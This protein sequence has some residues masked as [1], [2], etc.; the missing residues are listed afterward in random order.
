VK[1]PEEGEYVISFKG[2]DATGSINISVVE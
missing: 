2:T 1:V